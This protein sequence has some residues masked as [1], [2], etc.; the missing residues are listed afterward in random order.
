MPTVSRGRTQSLHD[1]ST[2]RFAISLFL[3][4]EVMFFAALVAAYIVLR[5]SSRTWKPDGFPELAL[6]LPLANTIVLAMSGVFV[7]LASRSIRR[8]DPGGLVAWLLVALA[9]GVAFVLGQVFEF[10]RLLAAEL[11][12]RAGDMFS[13]MFYAMAGLHALHVAGGVLLLVVVLMQAL[14]GRY[15]QR[16][17]A[18]VDL[19]VCYWELVVVVWLFF[20]SILYVF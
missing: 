1:P 12:I 10:R 5:F 2:A 4:A 8:E 20:F 7:V 3:V 19:A 9:S 13:G 16:R 15:H 6:G 18:A 17:R 14:R 11:P